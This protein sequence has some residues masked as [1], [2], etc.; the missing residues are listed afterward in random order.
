MP[1]SPLLH[2]F[3]IIPYHHLAS[4]AQKTNVIWPSCPTDM[5]PL[6][7]LHL[8]RGSHSINHNLPVNVNVTLA[9]LHRHHITT[10]ALHIHHHA[11][12]RRVLTRHAAILKSIHQDPERPWPSAHFFLRGQ[13]ETLP[14]RI[15]KMLQTCRKH[16]F[17]RPLL[18]CQCNVSIPWSPSFISTCSLLYFY[19]LHNHTHTLPLYLHPVLM[20]LSSSFRQRCPENVPRSK[21]SPPVKHRNR[22]EDDYMLHVHNSRRSLVESTLSEGRA[23]LTWYQ[24]RC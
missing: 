6:A 17:P 3:S 15:R 7:S 14:Q 24:N 1:R 16:A 19:T 20:I 5:I 22:A 4:T 12:C 21:A 8:P 9:P 23:V 2:L 10:H 18:E 13:G 11:I